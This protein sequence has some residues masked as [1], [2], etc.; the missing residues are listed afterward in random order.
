[1]LLENI[2]KVT[3]VD[4]AVGSVLHALHPFSKY[5]AQC[6]LKRYAQ[7]T[8]LVESLST[9]LNKKK[10]LLKREFVWSK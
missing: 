5:I 6:R 1:M 4:S 7:C 8:T 9:A 3:L 10:N 2:Q